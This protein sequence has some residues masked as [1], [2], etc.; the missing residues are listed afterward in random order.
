MKLNSITIKNFRALDDISL[1]IEDDLTLIVGKNNT[2]K[3]S[4]FEALNFF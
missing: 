3:T 1:E 2:G 4:V